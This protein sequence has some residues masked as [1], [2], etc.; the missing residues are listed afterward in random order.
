MSSIR[1][2]YPTIDVCKGLLI[3]FVVLGHSLEFL[4][5][6][7]SRIYLHNAIYI[8]H[9]PAFVAI[10]GFLSR[11]KA[12]GMFWKQQLLL[13][14][15]YFVFQAL[16]Y[17]PG[18]GLEKHS[19]TSFFVIS[20]YA[21]WYLP[22]LFIWRTLIQYCGLRIKRH[23]ALSMLLVISASLLIGY[24][25]I[26]NQF[27]IQRLVAFSPFFIG[28]YLYND[29]LAPLW[30]NKKLRLCVLAFGLI[31]IPF[32]VVT[33]NGSVWCLDCLCCWSYSQL[34]KLSTGIF[35]RA[36]IFLSSISLIDFLFFLSKRLL[37]LKNI[38]M[39]G[40]HSLL[41]YMLHP[42]VI[43]FLSRFLPKNTVLAIVIS[44]V[45]V[46]VIGLLGERTKIQFILNP[47]SSILNILKEK[48]CLE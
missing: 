1:T 5:S 32:L 16:H 46:L 2:Y 37:N 39:T 21:M 18:F 27:N 44:L 3:F 13:I 4:G 45:I 29:Y 33:R 47:F 17:I 42:F 14:E 7:P 8:F 34:E 9:I 28:G 48:S 11:Q 43:I 12:T 19:L 35:Y 20:E 15:T 23:P 10:S 41:I 25:P 31:A 6:N 30:A 24:I 36:I 22:C 40:R 38:G 26:D